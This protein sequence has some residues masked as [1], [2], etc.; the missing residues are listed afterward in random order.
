MSDDGGRADAGVAPSSAKAAPPAPKLPADAPAALRANAA[1]A[2][3]LA[4]EGT[5]AL[6]ARLAKLAGD[7]VAVNRW[8]SWCGPC[9]AEHPYF[10][11]SVARHGARVAFVGIDALDAH[12]APMTVFND[13]RGRTIHRKLGG[14][15]SAAALEAG[16]RRYALEAA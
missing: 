12:G 15:P 5:V 11:K 10:A 8:A 6:K 14:Y 1:D 13:A 2:N 7:P 16:S 9:R 4:G 3:R